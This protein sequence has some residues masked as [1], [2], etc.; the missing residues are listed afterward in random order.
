[1]ISASVCSLISQSGAV[2]CAEHADKIGI[3]GKRENAPGGRDAAVMDITPRRG[4]NWPIV[5]IDC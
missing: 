3:V 1:M 4:G 2:A 5:K